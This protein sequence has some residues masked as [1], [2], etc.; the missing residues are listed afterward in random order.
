MVSVMPPQLQA[1]D[2]VLCPLLWTNLE[3]MRLSN[4]PDELRALEGKGVTIDPPDEPDGSPGDFDM[5][6]ADVER[7][8]A[9]IDVK[10]VL[11]DALSP[12]GLSVG[13]ETPDGKFLSLVGDGVPSGCDCYF[14]MDNNVPPYAVRA[15]SR[16]PMCVV[17]HANQKLGEDYNGSVAHAIGVHILRLKDA[18]SLNSEASR[19]EIKTLVE[20]Q[21]ATL[22]SGI[23]LFDWPYAPN[24]GRQV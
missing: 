2:K 1:A 9:H 4:A 8:R 7:T 5:L 11:R 3:F 21:T 6:T 12:H 20:L 17:L 22:A 13:G 15:I 10:V 19:A 14:L 18:E 24:G 16:A 23:R